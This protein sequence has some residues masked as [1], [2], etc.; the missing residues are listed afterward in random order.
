M[1]GKNKALENKTE[2][3]E[4]HNGMLYYPLDRQN[5]VCRERII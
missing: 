5:F 3:R 4:H 1:E 2:T